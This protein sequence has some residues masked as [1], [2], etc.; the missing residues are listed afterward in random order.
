MK[1]FGENHW[2]LHFFLQYPFFFLEEFREATLVEGNKDFLPKNCY[3]ALLVRFLY[4]ASPVEVTINQSFD[5]T[6]IG[7][8]LLC[9]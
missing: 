6:L 1:A 5:S 8:S 7:S 2:G 3:D 4:D 9:L